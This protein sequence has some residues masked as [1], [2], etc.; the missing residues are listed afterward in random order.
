MTIAAAELRA[1]VFD[2]IEH[3]GI[4]GVVGVLRNGDGPTIL[5]RA[6]MDAL[7]VVEDT[8]LHYASTTSDIMHACGHDVHVACLVGAVRELM[9]TRADW[10]GHRTRRSIPPNR[11]P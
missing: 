5:L 8:G 4:T 6:D 7:P 9:A 2:V 10:R 3:I 1:A 11:S